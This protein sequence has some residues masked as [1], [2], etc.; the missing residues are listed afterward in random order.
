[1]RFRW[2]S[3]VSFGAVNCD[4]KRFSTQKEFVDENALFS[5][6]LRHSRKERC[7]VGSYKCCDDEKAEMTRWDSEEKHCP[8][9]RRSRKREKA[10]S[11]VEDANDFQFQ[12]CQ[13]FSKRDRSC[14]TQW[15]LTRKRKFPVHFDCDR[16]TDDDEMK[17]LSQER[18][19]KESIT[20]N[21]HQERMKCRVRKNHKLCCRD[22]RICIWCHHIWTS[23]IQYHGQT[24]VARA[25]L[26]KII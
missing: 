6:R 14:G 9:L 21:D 1:M 23:W 11:E 7:P 2:I 15:I 12:K 3:F 8:F 26:R 16:W 20:L 5:W 10:G 13:W 4:T 25:H 18:R 22:C 19:E 17:K 24:T